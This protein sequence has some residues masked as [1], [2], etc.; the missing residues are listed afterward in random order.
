MHDLDYQT[1]VNYTFESNDGLSRSWID[2][3]VCS[4]LSSSLVTDVC[5]L[6]SGV[7]LSDHIPLYFNLQSLCTSIP[8]SSASPSSN[9]RYITWDLDNYKEMVSQCLPRLPSDVLNCSSTDCTHHMES[10]DNYAH[11]FI[12]ILIDCG[13][14]C[15][16]CNTRSSTHRFVD[17]KD[18]VG[19]LKETTNFW[20]KVWLEAGCPSLGVLFHIKRCAKS[21][22]KY[23][24]RQLKCRHHFILR[25]KL[26]KSFARKRKDDF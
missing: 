8:I 9:S 14:R 24:V 6:H 23:A 15:L 18:G 4:R 16:P 7:N 12:S 3:I 17:W 20:H 1:S 2:H 19:K 5:T 26:A 25:E 21:R 11:Q 10:L 13:F 22:Y